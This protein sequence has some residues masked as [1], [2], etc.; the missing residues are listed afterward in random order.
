MKKNLSIL[1]S[2]LLVSSIFAQEIKVGY[3]NGPSC[4]PCGYLMDNVKQIKNTDITYEKF[5]DP[6]ALLPKMLKNE[7]D[8]GFLPVNVAAKVYNS[9]NKNIICCAIVGYGNLSLITTDKNVKSLE[10]LKGK[11][12]Y[13][14]GQGATPDYIFKYLL[15]NKNIS[16]STESNPDGVTLD[17]SIA[18]NNLPAMLLSGKIEY[19][20]LPEPFV[21]IAKTKSDK[22]IAI[23]LQKTEYLKLNKENYP[24]T[25]MVVTKNFADENKALLD[26]F[27]NEY[28]KASKWTL[29]NP[30]KAGVLCEKYELGLPASVLEKAIP[31]SNY[32]FISDKD[33]KKQIENL[34]K[35]F[36]EQE[37]S[38]IG[39]KLPDDNFYY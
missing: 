25:V 15:S 2:F 27:I 17:F 8:I 7:I 20:V 34:L 19:A 3:L 1:I 31:N 29:S 4:V 10:D 14:A 5:A 38:S 28:K 11:T 24:L 23:D 39:G 32:I 36:L 22:V 13:V 18:A 12:V 33:K 26:S 30:Q 37:P 35:I 6:Q 16:Y 9:T 21:T